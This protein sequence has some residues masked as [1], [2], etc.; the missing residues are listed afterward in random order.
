MVDPLGT[1]KEQIEEG[2]EAGRRLE[3]ALKLLEVLTDD[4]SRDLNWLQKNGNLSKEDYNWCNEQA[5]TFESLIHGV[6]E[7]LKVA[8]V[9]T[10][11]QQCK[12]IRDGL[13]YVRELVGGG[14][15]KSTEKTPIERFYAALDVLGLGRG[16]KLT[17]REISKRILLLR[18]QHNTDDP[19]H[20]KTPEE[21]RRNTER[22][23]QINVV[24]DDLN[25][26]RR[27]HNDKLVDV[28]V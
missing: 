12:K 4:A 19:D 20:G 15:A 2:I 5:K 10:L 17:W 26:L 27:K 7:A 25:D 8:E 14:R 16:S 23:Q 3:A 28:I 11:I 6:D 13:A 1:P 22:M 18:K 21:M 9:E 24:N